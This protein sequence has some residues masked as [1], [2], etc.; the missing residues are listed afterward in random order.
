MRTGQALLAAYCIVLA[1][2]IVFGALAVV[3]LQKTTERME[4]VISDSAERVIEV[5]RVRATS[6]RLGLAIRSYLLLQNTDL[7]STT[8]E[9]AVR[10]SE[11]LEALAERFEGSESAG[12][13][14][15]ARTLHERGR[16]E[17]NRILSSARR[18]SPAESIETV[19][20]RGQPL[21]EQLELVLD[22]LSLRESQEFKRAVHDAT[23]AAAGATRLLSG[24]AVVGLTIAI[25]LTIALVRALRLLARSRTE[26]EES[27]LKLEA[28]NSDLDSFVGRTA[29]DLRNVI[30]PLSLTADMLATKSGDAPDLKRHAE[31][32]DR[33]GRTAN[34]L[35]ESY[36]IFARAGQ[37]P[38]PNDSSRVR[39]VLA[40]VVED[41]APVAE[42]ERAQLQVSGDDAVVLCSRSFLHTILMN[43]IGNGLKFLDGGTRREVSVRVQADADVCQITVT[44][45]GPGIPA[46]A[47]LK[48]FEPFY[49]SPGVKAPGTGIGLATVARIVKAHGGSVTVHSFADQGTTFTVRLPRASTDL[50][51]RAALTKLDSGVPAEVPPSPH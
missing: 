22:E 45:G 23:V 3:E 35:I 7:R 16:L 14:A 29:H 6:D 5:E 48:I 1:M 43:L 17:L 50:G 27:L 42:R 44:D 10:F 30:S 8:E 18:L 24:L 4:A 40:E 21:R 19:E 49:R 13:V 34:G 37:P 12:L 2:G 41:L 9:A 28:V 26:L 32:L 25:G 15:R 39:D 33:I 31:R 46:G 38:N 11:R 51:E 47:E 20:R 36:L